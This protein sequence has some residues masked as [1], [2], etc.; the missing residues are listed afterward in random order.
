MGSRLLGDLRIHHSI[1]LNANDNRDTLFVIISD[2]AVCFGY[3]S[4]NNNII[5]AEVGTARK[6]ANYGTRGWGE[7]LLMISR[8]EYICS[9]KETFHHNFPVRVQ[10]CFKV[11]SKFFAEVAS[12]KATMYLRRML[13]IF[14]Q[15]VMSNST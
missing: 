11:E 2:F 5:L 12:L 9:R 4:V 14:E 1:C 15:R 13:E 3:N 8:V 6:A 10:V 7:F